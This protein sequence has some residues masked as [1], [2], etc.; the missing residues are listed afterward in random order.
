MGADKF[1]KQIPGAKTDKIDI[2]HIWDNLDLKDRSE[3][4]RFLYE[5]GRLNT[6]VKNSRKYSLSTAGPIH[7]C[8]QLLLILHHS[9]PYRPR[10]Y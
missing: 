6:P 3:V 7:A 5:V 2:L 9:F 1:T 4:E 10:C 8:P